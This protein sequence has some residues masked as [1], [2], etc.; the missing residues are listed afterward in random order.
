MKLKMNKR[1]TLKAWAEKFGVDIHIAEKYQRA[2]RNWQ[3]R[4]SAFARKYGGIKSK[5][6]P[7]DIR[8]LTPQYG[9][10]FEAYIESRAAT[11][12]SRA[13]HATQYLKA[14]QDTYLVNL[15]KEMARQD[16]DSV[17]AAKLQEWVK[18]A[19]T[20]EKADLIARMGGAGLT[21]LGGSPT[22]MQKRFKGLS[23]K[24]RREEYQE[25]SYQFE[26][27]FSKAQAAINEVIG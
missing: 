27:D 14:R 6:I 20:Q 15:A 10:D 12:A 4:V 7:V 9:L 26:Y 21:I 16:P 19:S 18:G 25:F 11:I 8:D 3:N 2:R 23:P 24:E 1:P 22:N 17:E 13:A 5:E